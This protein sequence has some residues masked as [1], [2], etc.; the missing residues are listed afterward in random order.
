MSSLSID[1]AP[2]H[3]ALN[4]ISYAYIAVVQG[5]SEGSGRKAFP[6]TSGDHIT[7]GFIS[8]DQIRFCTGTHRLYLVLE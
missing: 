1:D 4:K 3:D 2:R 7:T 5:T 8:I 6:R